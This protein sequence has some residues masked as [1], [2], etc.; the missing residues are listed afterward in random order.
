[1]AFKGPSWDG[2]WGQAKFTENL[3]AFPFNQDQPNPSRWTVPLKLTIHSTYLGTEQEILF[4]ELEC[5]DCG[6]VVLDSW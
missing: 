1:M 2:G 5:A 4:S 6:L 3:R